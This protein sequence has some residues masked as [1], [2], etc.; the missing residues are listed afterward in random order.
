MSY[1]D[2]IK[3]ELE[4]SP[5]KKAEFDSLNVP[6]FKE[7]WDENRHL[8]KKPEHGLKKTLIS[9]KAT[10]I[11]SL[12]AGI[13]MILSLS[14]GLYFGL[15]PERIPEYRYDDKNIT[16]KEC[17]DNDVM[18][19]EGLLLPDINILLDKTYN[20]GEHNETHEAVYFN[21]VGIYDNGEQYREIKL[22]IIIQTKYILA[23]EDKYNTENKIEVNGHKLSVFDN[24]YDEPFYR[25]KLGFK[26][27]DVRYY[28][29]YDTIEEND[30]T[31]FL[32]EFL[33]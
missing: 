6:A 20:V 12:T 17:S 4:S 5:D 14:M 3:Q 2:K 10:R 7:F 29:D 13:I 1:Y 18:Q 26:V 31:S 16:L 27:G 25:Y 28:I 9:R 15:R 8:L 32:E 30:Y 23:G 19:T 11:L 24:G 21:I 22:R 33:K